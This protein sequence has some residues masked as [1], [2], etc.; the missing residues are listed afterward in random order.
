MFVVVRWL[1]VVFSLIVACCFR[2]VVACNLLLL[3]LLLSFMFRCVC[4]RLLMVVVDRSSLVVVGCLLLS[5]VPIV[6]CDIFF[7]VR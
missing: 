1:F 5:Y 7:I 2:F 3:W 4:S 6:V